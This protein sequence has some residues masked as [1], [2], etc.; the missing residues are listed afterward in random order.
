MKLMPY[1]YNQCVPF[2]WNVICF[3]L[4]LFIVIIETLF[5][6]FG[7]GTWKSWLDSFSHNL[8]ESHVTTLF[9]INQLSQLW[10]YIRH[11]FFNLVVIQQ[12]SYFKAI[13][14]DHSDLVKLF[15][16]YKGLIFYVLKFLWS[17]SA[18]NELY[19]PC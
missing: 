1:S 11:R 4:A 16:G 5:T 12:A 15:S 7:L 19:S 9:Y 2:Q 13:S 18:L 17:F 6:I 10:R 8:Q 14:L 3:I